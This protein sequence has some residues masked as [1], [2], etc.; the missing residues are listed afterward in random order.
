MPS[1][2][3]DLRLILII[4]QTIE[5]QIIAHPN[6]TYIL[7]GDFNRDVALIGRQNENGDIP[8]Q[9]ED[10]LWHTYIKNLAFTYIPINPNYSK[11]GGHIYTS[12]SLI[13]GFFIKT[14]NLHYTHLL[15]LLNKT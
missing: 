4:Q 5:E 1:H 15:Q 11:Q 14:Q 13:D 10:V 6:H 7:D 8:P 12:T 3:E 9:E 2:N